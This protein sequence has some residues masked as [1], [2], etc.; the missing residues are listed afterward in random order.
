VLAGNSRGDAGAAPTRLA[1][2]Y[3]LK[4]D[5]GGMPAQSERVDTRAAIAWLQRKIVFE[6]EPL[7]EVA[8]EF[9]RYGTVQFSIEDTGLR[10]LPVS[11]VFNA[12]DVNS[13]AEFL[14]TLDGVRVER[15]PARI[16]VMG[17]DAVE[18]GGAPKLD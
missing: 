12:Y 10:A 6:R 8:E 4:I 1:A 9:N 5:G 2:G 7:G 13:F 3:R 15:T 14:E 11:G 18:A 16:R 17:Q